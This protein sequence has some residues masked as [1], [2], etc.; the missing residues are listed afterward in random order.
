MRKITKKV[1][2]V[3]VGTLWGAKAQTKG[4]NSSITDETEDCSHSQ[5]Q[6]HG[7]PALTA[8]PSSFY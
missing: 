2:C 8:D 7:K 5:L 1:V 6:R 3:W 4:T